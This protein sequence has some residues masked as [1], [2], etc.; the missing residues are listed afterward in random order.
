MLERDVAALSLDK[1]SLSERVARLGEETA[2]L[3]AALALQVLFPASVRRKRVSNAGLDGV[4]RI[5]R[6]AERLRRTDRQR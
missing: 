4:G 6:S 2:G 5:K 3:R 1:R